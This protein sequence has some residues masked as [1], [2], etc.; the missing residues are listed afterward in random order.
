MAVSLA[1]S[2]SQGR[3]MALISCGSSLRIG[4]PVL[5]LLAKA[6]LS[7]SLKLPP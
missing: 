4:N 5:L 2:H 3:A 1:K 7:T 6:L